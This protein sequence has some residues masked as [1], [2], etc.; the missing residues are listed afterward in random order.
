MSGRPKIGI[1]MRLEIETRRFYLGRDYSEAIVSA[2]GDAVHIGLI[3]D[4]EYIESTLNGL[5]GILLPGSD[6]DVDP[7]FYG[8]EPHRNLKRVV[9]EKD[10]TDRM[11]INAAEKLHLPILAICY[12]MQALNV[13]RGGSLVQDIDSQIVDPVK[14]E[15]GI[16]LARGSHTITY[17][18]NWLLSDAADDISRSSA[19]R[20]NSHHHQAVGRVGGSLEAVAF[21]AD[22]V[23]ESIQDTRGGRMV[24]GVQ[25]HPELSWADD[26]LSRTIFERFVANCAETRGQRASGPA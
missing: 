11:V 18:P 23:I 22:G 5:D 24:L 7:H 13:A 21:A 16:P 17:S 10:E 15:Q 9:P 6:T 1:T 2:G 3:P 25:W 8:E 19:V 4:K 26:R 14:H 12:G 20:V